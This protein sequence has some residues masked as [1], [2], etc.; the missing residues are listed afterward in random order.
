MIITG[1]NSTNPF[2]LLN[3]VYVDSANPLANAASIPADGAGLSSVVDLGI[4]RNNFVQASGAIQPVYKRNIVNG[5]NII[6]W[7]GFDSYMTCAYDAVKNGYNG[8]MTLTFAW[9]TNVIGTGTNNRMFGRQNAGT[10]SGFSTGQID[11]MYAFTA[12][13]LTDAQSTPI[14]AAGTWEVATMRYNGTDTVNFFR[15]DTFISTDTG[16][17]TVVANTN[18]L[19]LGGFS[20]TLTGLNWNGDLLLFGWAWRQLTNAQISLLHQYAMGRMGI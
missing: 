12:T 9:L 4:Y 16:S 15:N 18:A 11:N 7:N 5:N 10:A 17:D 3:N 19:I 14:I 8:P 20:S 1:I 13:G 6:R 2:P